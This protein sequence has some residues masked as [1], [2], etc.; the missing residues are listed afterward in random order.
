M[1]IFSENKAS[2]LGLLE[3]FC[4][5]SVPPVVEDGIVFCP[6]LSCLIDEEKVLFRHPAAHFF[7]SISHDFDE[8]ELSALCQNL[9]KLVVHAPRHQYA[10]DEDN[11]DHVCPSH[12]FPHTERLPVIRHDIE[13]PWVNLPLVLQELM[14]YC[15][16][17]QI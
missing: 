7:V 5:S 11:V 6:F 14:I 12:T 17:R 15:R 16:L 4:T 10:L 8:Y 1:T 2:I 13:A 9:F 3:F